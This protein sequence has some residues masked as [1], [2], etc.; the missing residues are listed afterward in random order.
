MLLDH[1]TVIFF[2]ADDESGFN[3]LIYQYL[4]G[5]QT[6]A[7]SR[8]RSITRLTPSQQYTKDARILQKK[9]SK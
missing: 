1:V 5:K 3:E 4:D 8:Y 7:A 2:I 6:T 9:A